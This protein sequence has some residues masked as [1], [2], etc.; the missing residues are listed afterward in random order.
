MATTKSKTAS[1]PVG[2]AEVAKPAPNKRKTPQE[3][4]KIRRRELLKS[5]KRQVDDGVLTIRQMTPAEKKKYA[6]KD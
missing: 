2:K 5:I 6:K 4:Q 3:Q 1:K